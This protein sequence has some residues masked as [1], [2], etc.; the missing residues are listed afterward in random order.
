MNSNEPVQS[1]RPTVSVVI[2]T[3][4]S[5]KTIVR[6]LS[7]V[8][9]QTFDDFEVVLI[10]DASEDRTV[11]VARNFDGLRIRVISN[12]E[13]LGVAA[14]RNL[15]IEQAT[16]E[17][18]AF[19]DSDDEWLPQKLEKQ[20]A[21]MT[22][23]PDGVFVSCEAALFGESGNYVGLVNPG[24]SR[25]SGDQAWKSL[26]AY[27]SPHTSTIVAERD[28]IL[29]AGDFNETLATGEDQDLWVRLALSGPVLHLD[30]VLTNVHAVSGSVS[31]RLRPAQHKIL[32]P[33]IIAHVER[34]KSSLDKQ[35]INWILRT[36]YFDIGKDLCIDGNIALG[37]WFLLKSVVR[38]GNLFAAAEI[39]VSF[40]WAGKAVKGLIKWLT[41]FFQR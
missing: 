22:N 35:E 7:S 32:L 20:I 30:E 9:Q 12:T 16:G 33:V 38:G 40:S 37:S 18:I 36:R 28:A 24:R 14:A 34:Q 4:N 23:A 5:E 11:E 10:D 3:Y 39:I 29:R 15:G 2:P 41:A 8:E 21:A 25:P 13:N 26:L 27:P 17:Y 1:R 6:A 19:L 31:H